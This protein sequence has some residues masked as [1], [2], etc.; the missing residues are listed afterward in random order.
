[1]IYCLLQLY[2]CAVVRKDAKKKTENEETRLFC[3]N[4]VIGGIS[5]EEARALGPPCWLRL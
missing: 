5:I 2:A 4:F 1:M 3:Q